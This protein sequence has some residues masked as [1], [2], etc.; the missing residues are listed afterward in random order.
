MADV[1]PLAGAHARVDPA[2]RALLFSLQAQHRGRGGYIDGVAGEMRE[3]TQGRRKARARVGDVGR[4]VCDQGAETACVGGF[5]VVVKAE[6][7][8]VAEGCS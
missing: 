1:Q 3:D 4:V 5:E 6:G 7:G 2:R 8:G